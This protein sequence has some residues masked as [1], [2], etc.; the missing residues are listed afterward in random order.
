MTRE[1]HA[2]LLARLAAHDRNTAAFAKLGR[3]LLSEF[4]AK[5]AA[6]LRKRLNEENIDDE[7][8]PSA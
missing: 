8:S 6:V 7:P 1:E 4:C 2:D 5:Q 3:T